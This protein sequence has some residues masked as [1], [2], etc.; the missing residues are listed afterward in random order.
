[1]TS[2]RSQ[3]PS[4]TPG[5]PSL[6]GIPILSESD[7]A[8]RATLLAELQV[9]LTDLG[10]RCVLARR[11]RLVLRFNLVPQPASGRTDPA[12]YIFTPGGTR[13]VTTDGSV[14]RLDSGQEFAVADPVA[15]VSAICMCGDLPPAHDRLVT[16]TRVP[17]SHARD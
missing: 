12:L 14:Y 9:T 3:A 16:R 5:A 8:S 15:A 11:Q 13:V 1:M 2:I 17:G 4:G 10:I 7:A 6:P